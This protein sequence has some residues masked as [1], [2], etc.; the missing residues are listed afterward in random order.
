[1]PEYFFID[2]VDVR[3]LIEGADNDIR[4]IVPRNY[5]LR[6]DVFNPAQ[7]EKFKEI[8][9]TT[10]VEKY[11]VHNY[12]G[13]KEP[14]KGLFGLEMEIEGV[15]LPQWPSQIWDF[16]KDGSLRG[17]GA[18]EYV[19][20]KPLSLEE[21]I[22]ALNTLNKNMIKNE[23][24]PRFSFRTSVHV[25]VNV[26]DLYKEEVASFLY[27]SHLLEDVLVE[28]SGEVRVGNRFCLRTRDAEGKVDSM[29]KW[30]TDKGMP[31]LRND[32]LKYAAINIVPI[33]TYG[34][35]EFRSLRGTLDIDIIV[36]WLEV[37]SNIKE[38]SR[39]KTPKQIAKAIITDRDA[40]LKQ[41]FGKHL[42]LFEYPGMDEDITHAYSLLI[43]IPYLEIGKS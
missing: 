22:K 7:F 14:I 5:V 28:Y 13:N 12:L 26:S 35:V 9:M 2:D 16:K 27:L 11:K 36:P 19:F 39:T 18:L 15:E 32:K 1:M 23:A 24:E 8:E 4:R 3:P 21:S 30:L 10:A 37:L 41:V 6:N 25:H 34:S 43:E 20:I 17:A 42:K 31:Q 33:T 29:C 38:Y 40:L